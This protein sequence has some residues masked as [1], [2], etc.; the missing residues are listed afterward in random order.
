METSLEGIDILWGAAAIGKA[1]G[2]SVRQTFH[3]LETRQLSG[4][5]KVGGRWCITRRALRENFEQAWMSDG[6]ADLA[7]HLTPEERHAFLGRSVP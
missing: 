2:L 4:A 1:L 7:R 3:L 6:L 5:R